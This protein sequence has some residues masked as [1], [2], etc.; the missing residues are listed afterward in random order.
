[1]KLSEFLGEILKWLVPVEKSGNIAKYRHAEKELEG[2]E[3][4]IIPK[5]DALAGG[6]PRR[7]MLIR[8]YLTGEGY[9]V[10]IDPLDINAFMH[11]MKAGGFKSP[12]PTILW[13]GQPIAHADW[14]D[15]KVS[16]VSIEELEALLKEPGKLE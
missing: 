6:F 5:L 13:S 16:S 11:T 4:W 12:N 10:L 14:S 3:W 9:L 8:K 15:E 1:M 2:T 7:Y